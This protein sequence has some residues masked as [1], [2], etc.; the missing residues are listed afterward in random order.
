MMQNSV[1]AQRWATSPCPR[2]SVRE[3]RL[4]YPP[5]QVL[6]ISTG[7]QGEP[8]S[9]LSRIAVDDHKHVK[10]GPGDTVVLSARAIPGNEKAI[11]RV[12]NHLTRRGA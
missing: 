3:Q 9:A 2:A 5:N 8:R 12:I 6:C 7:T 4:N 10:V 1:I 11:G